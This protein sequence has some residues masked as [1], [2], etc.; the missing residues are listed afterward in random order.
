MVENLAPAAGAYAAGA[1]EGRIAE[2]GRGARSDSDLGSP[3]R[4]PVMNRAH[5][6]SHRSYPE[7]PVVLPVPVEGCDACAHAAAWR[8]AYRTGKGT[9]DGC[10]N[11]SAAADC[12][13]EIR[14]HPHHPRVTGLPLGT[15]AVRP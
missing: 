5:P 1:A 9:A 2:G 7:P 15:P 6:P 13:L 10:T 12:S 4:D 8:Q 11:R 14:D 3:G